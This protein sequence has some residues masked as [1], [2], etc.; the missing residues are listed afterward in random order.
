[1][2]VDRYPFDV[3]NIVEHQKDMQ[4]IIN[5][6]KTSLNAQT[7][8][9]QDEV[10]T[11]NRLSLLTYSQNKRNSEYNKMMLI[12][13]VSIIISFGIYG[14]SLYIPFIPQVFITLII[15]IICSIALIWAY[16]IY[17]DIQSRSMINYDELKLDSLNT[18]SVSDEE[19]AR[20]LASGNLLGSINL[21]G[22]IGA[23]C[24]DDGTMWNINNS[25]C[26]APCTGSTVSTDYDAGGPWAGYEWDNVGRK[27][28]Q[29][30]GSEPF[31][32]YEGLI[33]NSHSDTTV[34]GSLNDKVNASNK[35]IEKQTAIATNETKVATAKATESK[36]QA[37]KSQRHQQNAENSAK[38]SAT[39][40]INS[41]QHAN[42]AGNNANIASSNADKAGRFANYS[43]N[44]ANTSETAVGKSID[45]T[46]SAANILEQAETAT[47]KLEQ[48]K[49]NVGK[50]VGEAR[51]LA[52]QNAN[53]TDSEPFTTL[54]FSVYK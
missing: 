43:E 33:S 22:C 3:S 53:L 52:E 6:T 8:A 9:I 13:I 37:N 42:K 54:K 48:V 27:C 24:C 10:E 29:I 16:Y 21:G 51:V 36:M 44:N 12:I 5:K 39:Q 30:G 23:G 45:A 32:T 46:V 4:S 26:M 18:S 41:A 35:F 7:E 1:M 31:T 14:F 49:N 50:L 34:G 2:T 15:S 40:S 17:L 20:N 38:R 47:S 25:T 11:K 19:R 28:Q